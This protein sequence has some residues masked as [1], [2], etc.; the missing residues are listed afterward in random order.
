LG[1]LDIGKVTAKTVR[2]W[3]QGV[4]KAPKLLRTK[5]EREGS[6]VG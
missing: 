5:K 3:L 2:D 6:P 1:E 4:E